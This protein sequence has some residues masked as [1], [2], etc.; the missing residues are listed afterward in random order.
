MKLTQAYLMTTL[1]LAI[2]SNGAL[3]QLT[4]SEMSFVTELMRQY[5]K[6]KC[7][8]TEIHGFMVTQQKQKNL[9][10]FL[11]GNIKDSDGY[12]VADNLENLFHLKG[13]LDSLNSTYWWRLMAKLNFRDSISPV[14]V[15]E[16]DNIIQAN[17][18]PDFESDLVI[19]TLQDLL[20]SRHNEFV[21]STEI[22]FK[23]LS[24]LKKPGLDFSF[25][26]KKIIT[27]LKIGNG[28]SPSKLSIIC[29]LR[30]L[31][32]DL[33]GREF[34]QASTTYK[35][36]EALFEGNNEWHSMDGG[37]LR[38]KARNNGDIEVL[39]HPNLAH[40]LNIALFSLYPNSTQ[41]NNAQATSVEPIEKV[42]DVSIINLITEGINFDS[43][44][45][46]LTMNADYRG[47]IAKSAHQI[48]EIL[49]GKFSGQHYQFDYDPRSE[50]R[51]IA[52]SGTMPEVA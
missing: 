5:Q 23:K 12:K 8:L 2:N 11:Y 10:H 27:S 19:Q 44:N 13:A 32:N 37:A 26:T 24:G 28:L 1:T 48:L 18:T 33:L 9:D 43:K 16:W 17:V 14:L 31:L 4:E 40:K 41:L 50:F 7:E 36:I 42:I 45:Y 38:L 29:E 21:K 22:A 20:T 34:H 15:K 39:I 25:D 35:N 46:Q 6:D 47:E 52:I 49:G 30:L 51:R 3:A